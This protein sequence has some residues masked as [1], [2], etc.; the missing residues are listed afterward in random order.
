MHLRGAIDA[1]NGN[2]AVLAELRGCVRVTLHFGVD[3][4]PRGEETWV[5]E[6]IFCVL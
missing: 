6:D 3:F 2:A 1:Q 4:L 5:L